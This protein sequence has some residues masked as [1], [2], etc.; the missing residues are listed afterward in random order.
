[1]G[2]KISDLPTNR[3][4]QTPHGPTSASGC[5]FL[6]YT[7]A[8]ALLLC[9]CAT[10]RKPEQA[11][12]QKSPPPKLVGI[13][14]SIPPERTFAL[15]QS[16]GTWDTP[17]GA[18]LTTR[19]TDNRTANLLFTGEKLGHFVAADIQSGSVEKGDAVYSRHVP[20]PDP[21][22]IGSSTAPQPDPESTEAPAS[23][24]PASAPQ[25]PA[26]PE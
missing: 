11:E 17:T 23:N 8:L 16:Y 12:N 13:V 9:S 19:G 22:A 18:I 2:G 21:T 10:T 4:S 5:G 15:I 26:L 1:M 3:R 20:K 24:P 7:L 6:K 14:A 25:E